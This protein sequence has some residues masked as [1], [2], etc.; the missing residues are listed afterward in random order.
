MVMAAGD[1]GDD[2]YHSVSL[3]LRF[4]VMGVVLLLAGTLFTSTTTDGRARLLR[5][6]TYYGISSILILKLNLKLVP[7]VARRN[8]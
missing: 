3:R 6:S 4:V 5:N 7:D 2:R 1:D 8:L